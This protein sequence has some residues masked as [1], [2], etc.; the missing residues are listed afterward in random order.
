MVMYGPVV[1]PMDMLYQAHNYYEIHF[2]SCCNDI[3][4]IA[5][6][7]TAL[8]D[9]FSADQQAIMN[10]RETFIYGR[11]TEFN[12]TTFRLCAKFAHRT[13]RNP[14]DKIYA[15]LGL[16]TMPTTGAQPIQPDYEI[17]IPT[18]Y[19][20]LFLDSLFSDNSLDRLT[21]SVVKD[22]FPQLPSWVVD[23]T[24]REIE[25][26]DCGR[27]VMAN[28]YKTA[29]ARS[30]VTQ[31]YGQSILVLGGFQIDW[32]AAAVETVPAYRGETDED[33]D[34]DRRAFE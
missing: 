24:N 9:L 19:R 15:L 33:Y 4:Q 28:L 8:A 3:Y 5:N 32:I 7:V 27:R 25:D 26:A 31:L 14:R 1:L 6:V 22:Q 30:R 34:S 16:V 2:A 11:K 20:R 13:S 18:L 10:L 23:L 21:Y 12:N 29:N 17:A